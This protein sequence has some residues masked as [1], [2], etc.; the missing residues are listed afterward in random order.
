MIIRL[1]VLLVV[2]AL[3]QAP[4]P[5]PPEPVSADRRPFLLGVLRRDG[6]VSPFA[7][8]DGSSWK[9]PWPVGIRSVD[10]PI[11]IDAIPKSWWGKS[12]APA[13]MTVWADGAAR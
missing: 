5:P 3:A 6:V 7:A 9:A 10:L 8:F 13:S 4:A 12:G 1:L 11:S 2:S